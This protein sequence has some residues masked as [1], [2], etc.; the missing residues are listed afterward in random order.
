MFENWLRENGVKRN[1]RLV[2]EQSPCGGVGLMLLDEAEGRETKKQ[3]CGEENA[4]NG[5]HAETFLVSIPFSLLIHPSYQKDIA[6]IRAELQQ[7]EAE[8]TAICQQTV[9]KLDLDLLAIYYFLIGERQ[10]GEQSFWFPYLALFPESVHSTVHWSE[11]ELQ[12]IV[13]TNLYQGTL[14]VREFVRQVHLFLQSRMDAAITYDDV[15]WAYSVF[16]S[17]TAGVMVEDNF[18]NNQNYRFSFLE[19]VP[20][21]V[22]F[23]DTLNHSLSAEV[24]YITCNANRQFQFQFQSSPQGKEVFNNYG[25]KSNE[26]LLLTY[27]FILPNNPHNSYWIQMA[28]PPDDPDCESK[29]EMLKR[30]NFGLRHHIK[31]NEVPEDLLRATRI[32]LLEEDEFYLLNETARNSFEFISVINEV[33][34]YNT[35]IGLLGVRLTEIKALPSNTQKTPRDISSDSS[36]PTL[37]ASIYVREQ[38]EILE[39]AVAHLKKKRDAFYYLQKSFAKGSEDIFEYVPKTTIDNSVSKLTN[40]FAS[41]FA[42]PSRFQFVQDWIACFTSNTMAAEVVDQQLRLKFNGEQTRFLSSLIIDQNTLRSDAEFVGL[43][44]ITA[45]NQNETSADLLSEFRPE[46][47]LVLYLIFQ[48]KVKNTDSKWHSFFASLPPIFQSFFNS[49]TSYLND[50]L[51]VILCEN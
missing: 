14:Q 32:L 34:V 46:L 41:Q 50:L 17:R 29:M 42:E 7:Y 38:V 48:S 51:P 1:P 27:G 15:L 47:L 4:P 11:L 23:L 44:G 31:L 24:K 49:D 20:C 37:L 30:M 36:S 26:E 39:A 21:L 10:K 25:P 2:V 43:F 45:E 13:H 3:K 18:S 35:L 22:P 8:W 5:V 12:N 6:Q 40:V 19:A 28:L 33:K 9:L 16:S